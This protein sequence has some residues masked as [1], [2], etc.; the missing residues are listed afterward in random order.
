MPRRQWTEGDYEA[1]GLVARKIRVPKETSDALDAL[2]EK[3]GL[4]GIADVVARLVE[5]EMNR[6]KKR[7][8]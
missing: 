7:K 5:S 3:W 2:A 8:R 4:K 1:K 6:S